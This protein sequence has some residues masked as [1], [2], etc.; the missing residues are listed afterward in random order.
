MLTQ[1]LSICAGGVRGGVVGGKRAAA[2]ASTLTS[3]K[4]PVDG[5]PDI[6]AT[7]N[8]SYTSRC[9]ARPASKSSS[10]N[11]CLE[12][13]TARGI[14]AHRRRAHSLC[15][16]DLANLAQETGA[17]CIQAERYVQLPEQPTRLEGREVL[18]LPAAY[19]LEHGQ[20]GAAR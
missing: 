15:L 19:E 11:P 14:A 17:P 10:E 6:G 9:H 1:P 12:P 2:Y 18:N 7:V 5:Y 16:D 4:A 3:L 13:P 8:A 20:L